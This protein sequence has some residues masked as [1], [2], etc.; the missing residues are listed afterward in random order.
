MRSFY[1]SVSVLLFLLSLS[2]FS[3]QKPAE[4][5]IKK[6][7]LFSLPLG[8]MEDELPLFQFEDDVFHPEVNIEMYEGLFYISES[9]SRKVM[10]F[11]SYGDIIGLLYNPETNPTPVLLEEKGQPDVITSRQA[12]P[13]PFEYVGEIGIYGNS[14]ILVEDM[15]AEGREEYDEEIGGVL[16]RVVLRFDR[17]GRLLDYLGQEGLGGTPFPYIQRVQV[18]SH[19][20]AVITCRTMTSWIVYWF[21]KEGLLGYKVEVPLDNLPLPKE[22]EELIAELED[23]YAD[24][25]RRQ[26]YLKLDYYRTS[27]QKEENPSGELGF[28]KSGVFIFDLSNEEYSSFIEIPKKFREQGDSGFL[29]EQKEEVLFEIVGVAS[30][31]YLF[32]LGMETISENKLLIMDSQGKVVLDGKIVLGDK[33]LLYETFQ[34]TPQ[35]ILTGV[36]SDDVEADVVWWRTDKFIEIE[37]QEES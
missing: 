10:I 7:L 5:N 18:T 23:V 17:N 34:V 8:T 20:E 6:D 31:G 24:I 13:Y 4:K 37:K 11:N 36:L 15:V 26:I 28:Y 30:G 22:E 3:C 2:M 32:F 35:G 16:N 27:F 29:E 33:E 25:D 21:S 14:L 12:T 1:I 9:R 19:G